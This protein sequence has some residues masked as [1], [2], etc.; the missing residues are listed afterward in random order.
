MEKEQ[1]LK[2]NIK[3]NF[4]L[5][6]FNIF[7]LSILINEAFSLI[8]PTEGWF[9]ELTANKNIFE[10]IANDEILLPPLY[11]LF[12]SFLNK[13][14]HQIILFRIFGIAFGYFL[15][16]QTS[17]FLF[18]GINVFLNK[19]SYCQKSLLA[20]TKLISIYLIFFII[21][22]SSYLLW[23]DFTIIVL[24]SQIIIVN[25]SIRALKEGIKPRKIFFYRLIWF[26]IA[27]G[28]FL[29]HSNMG[30]YFISLEVCFLLIYFLNNQER[31]YLSKFFKYQLYTFLLSIFFILKFI[32]I[33]NNV[34]LLND[35]VNASINAKG[36]SDIVWKFILNGFNHI[37]NE[38]KRF[39]TL[40]MGLSLFLYCKRQKNL[41]L[42][43]LFLFISISSFS[44]LKFTPNISG[45]SVRSITIYF[46]LCLFFIL[47]KVIYFKKKNSNIDN[48]KITSIFLMTFSAIGCMIGNFTSAGLG[49]N[50]YYIGFLLGIILQVCFL[51]EFI[52]LINL[53][54]LNFKISK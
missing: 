18:N 30:V 40:L 29:K 27:L 22:F 14:S 19:N 26:S 1:K 46:I 37:L 50:G 35:F 6:I 31:K 12:I 43:G 52:D 21:N 15:Y 51:I 41:G 53:K 44:I 17:I 7:I 33:N 39:D 3:N 42:T 16:N 28:I 38:L 20:I 32:F 23:Y 2:I 25:L 10:I 5:I 34:S 4:L 24:L 9:I 8:P 48:K 47:F 13:I 45:Y 36:G 54:I 11:P 49:Y